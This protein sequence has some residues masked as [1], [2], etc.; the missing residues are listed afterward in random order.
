MAEFCFQ[1]TG[2]HAIC[3]G[4]VQA[5]CLTLPS[6]VTH[7]TSIGARPPPTIF[8]VGGRESHALPAAAPP[9]LAVVKTREIESG[10]VVGRADL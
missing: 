5:G 6:Y 2:L 1:Y 9:S 10:G 7:A 4:K 3:V 8:K